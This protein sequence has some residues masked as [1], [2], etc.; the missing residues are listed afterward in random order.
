MLITCKHG[1]LSDDASSSWT[2]ESYVQGR[3]PKNGEL[4]QYFCEADNPEDRYAVAM[5][6]QSCVVGHE[7]QMISTPCSIFSGSLQYLDSGL[8][9]ELTALVVPKSFLLHKASR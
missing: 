5:K 1:A 4:L 7:P 2:T 8:D 3:E 6:K 9:Q